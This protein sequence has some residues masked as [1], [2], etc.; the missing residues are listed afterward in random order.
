[1]AASYRKHLSAN[2]VQSNQPGSLPRIEVTLYGFTDIGA[3]F[4]ECVRFRKNIDTGAASG[5]S[6]FNGFFDEEKDFVQGSLQEL[7]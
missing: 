1:M 7:D 2:D 6:T 4:V 5:E 3:E